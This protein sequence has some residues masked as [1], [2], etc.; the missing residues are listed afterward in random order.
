MRKSGIEL[1]QMTPVD[2]PHPLSRRTVLTGGALAVATL[3]LGS[4]A[5]PSTMKKPIIPPRLAPGSRVALVAPSGAS[6][7]VT[8]IEAAVEK[9]RSLG[10]TAIPSRHI[11]AKLG[12]LAGTDQARADDLMTAFLDPEIDGIWCLRGGYGAA[13]I[14][15]YLDFEK[16]QSHPKMLIGYSDITALHLGLLARANLA[17]F[18]GPV[19]TST[20]NPF[21]IQNL[22][23]MISEAT[24]GH[25][26][27][28]PAGKP[29]L[30]A[31][32]EGSLPA[33][34]GSLVGGNLTVFQSLFGTPFMPSLRN[35]ILFFEDIGEDPYRVD[36][37]LTQLRLAG[38][39][40]QAR[41]ILFGDFSKRESQPDP[42]PDPSPGEWDMATVLADRTKDLGIPILTHVPFGHISEKITLMQGGSA[43]LSFDPL[44]LK[45]GND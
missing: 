5:R 30:A 39:L 11:E 26:I 41:A 16:I 24:P 37:M 19:G 20:F 3:A 14:L 25:L 7:G 44:T 33:V 45:I 22:L 40:Q 27:E 12:Y 8:E 34:R 38:A 13:R 29:L 42:D 10:F 31:L 36:R 15:P 6:D 9:L 23:P 18:H 32:R 35:A 4:P 2:Q 28:P 17:S 21:T 43:Q 1:W